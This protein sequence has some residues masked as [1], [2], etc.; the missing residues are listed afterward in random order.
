MERGL[1]KLKKKTSKAMWIIGS[2]SLTIVGILVIPTVIDK[3][4]NEIYKSGLKSKEI[5]FDNLGPEIVKKE[6]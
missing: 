3:L 1:I 4:G 6:D 5:G 2:I